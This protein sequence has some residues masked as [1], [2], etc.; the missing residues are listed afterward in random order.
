ME[1]IGKEVV[2]TELKYYPAKLEQ[3]DYVANTYVCPECKDS[4]EP[5]FAKDFVKE[6]LV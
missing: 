2:R 3:I 1:P 4:L 6:P 5:T